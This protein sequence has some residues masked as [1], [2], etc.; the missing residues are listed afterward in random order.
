MMTGSSPFAHLARTKTVL[1]TTYRRDGAPVA[2]PVSI[3]VDGPRAFFRTYDGAWKTKRLHNN[4]TVEVA[5]STFRGRQTGPPMRARAA[6]A[7]DRE[8]A[9]AR[10]L[11]ARKYPILQGAMVPIAHRLR[12]YKTLHYELTALTGED[13]ARQV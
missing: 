8:S 1:L 9:H 4:P 3:V 12:K 5:P 2:T 11:L 7:G 10:Q 6:L 13:G